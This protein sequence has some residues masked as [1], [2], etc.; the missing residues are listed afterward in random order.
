MPIMWRIAALWIS[1]HALRVEGDEQA[2]KAALLM[3]ISTHALR[4]EGDI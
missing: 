3:A 2:Q 4:V 1:T